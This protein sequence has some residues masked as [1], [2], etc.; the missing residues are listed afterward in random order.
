MQKRRI[1]ALILTLH[2][3]LFTACEPKDPS[4]EEG[5][6]NYSGVYFGK[7]FSENY[8][9]GIED[10]CTT[11]KGTYQKSHQLFNKDED[12]NKGW[13]LGRNRCRHLLVLELD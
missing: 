8:K 5:A 2:T 3:C 11:S 10:G 7:N 13:F 1:Q 12:Y 9:K 4:F 6:Y